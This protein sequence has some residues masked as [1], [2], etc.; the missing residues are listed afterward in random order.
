MAA[1][2]LFVEE[3]STAAVTNSCVYVSDIDTEFSNLP[4][5]EEDHTVTIVNLPR[6]GQ[7]LWLNGSTILDGDKFPLHVGLYLLMFAIF[8]TGNCSTSDL[9]LGYRRCIAV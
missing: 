6:H 3:G 1:D 2:T 9:L 4:S 5:T 7:L 8:P